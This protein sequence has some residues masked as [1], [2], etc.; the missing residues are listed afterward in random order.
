MQP[1]L[2]L[3]TSP[4]FPRALLRQ[5]NQPHCPL[6]LSAFGVGGLLGAFFWFL[7]GWFIQVWGRKGG[8]LG[9]L[10]VVLV[11]GHKEVGDFSRLLYA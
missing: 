1:L 11:E 6:H 3:P 4:A 8:S 2:G 5:A 10:L 7:G 9:E